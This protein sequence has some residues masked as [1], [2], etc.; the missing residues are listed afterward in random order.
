MPGDLPDSSSRQ[1]RS[2]CD[3]KARFWSNRWAHRPLGWFESVPP[4][5]PSP[6]S[7]N[8]IKTFL[9]FKN[10]GGQTNSLIMIIKHKGEVRG[11][12]GLNQYCMSCHHIK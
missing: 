6:P 2:S 1:V 5:V 12:Q 9:L 11:L 8:W 10:G 4:S 3:L 7:P